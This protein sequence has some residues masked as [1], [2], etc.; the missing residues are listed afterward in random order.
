MHDL[1]SKNQSKLERVSVVFLGSFNPAIM[2][3]AWFASH[4]LIQ[5]DENNVPTGVTLH[6]SHR[7]ITDFKTESF[8]LQVI[9]QRFSLTSYDSSFFD[10]LRDLAVGTFRILNHTPIGKMGINR[11]FH[12]QLPDEKSYHQLGDRLAPKDDWRNVLD[13][14][15]LASLNMQGEREDGYTGFVRVKVEPSSQVGP[16]GIFVEVNDHYETPDA[17]AAKGCAELIGLLE[18]VWNQ[19]IARSEA[20]AHKMIF[21]QGTGDMA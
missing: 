5:S 7:D 15:R 13:T 16:W 1:V 21:N 17:E 2:H 19:S 4:E 14:P 9:P 20:I 10:S 3:P 18:Q 8:H 12:F 11:E 6:L